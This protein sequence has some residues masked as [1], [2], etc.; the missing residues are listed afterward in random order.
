MNNDIQIDLIE[1]IDTLEMLTMIGDSSRSF[2]NMHTG[3]IVN[4]F[5]DDDFSDVEDE[6]LEDD[7]IPSHYAS[8]PM[9]E[10]L[11]EYEMMEEFCY[12]ITNRKIQENLLDAIQGKG[13]FGRFRT[14]I[15]CHNIEDKWYKFREACLKEI[16]I[17]FCERHGLI[18]HY[19]PRC[20]DH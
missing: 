16:A 10:E 8:L 1:I 15:H 19:S 7:W 2:V 6:D 17:K 4:L 14:A 9:R 11:N 20:G 3:Q 13:A 5:E 18:Y 12:S